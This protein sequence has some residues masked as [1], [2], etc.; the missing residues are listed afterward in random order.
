[1]WGHTKYDPINMHRNETAQPA[2]L[3]VLS[4]SLIFIFAF[5]KNPFHK[6]AFPLCAA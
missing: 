2:I 3:K 6:E 1:M 5:E 4:L